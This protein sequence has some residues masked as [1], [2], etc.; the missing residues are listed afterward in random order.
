MNSTVQSYTS[1][2]QADDE[3]SL[4]DLLLVVAENFWLL[5]IGSALAAVLGFVIS[6]LLQ[7][8]YVSTA[9]VSGEHSVLVGGKVVPL[10]KPT[11][12]V[13]LATS[14]AT[15]SGAASALEQ[16]GY[17]AEA[18]AL[19]AQSSGGA[20][21][22]KASIARNSAAINL[23]ATAGSAQAAQEILIAVVDSLLAQSRPQAEAL[24]SLQ[25]AFQRDAATLERSRAIEASLAQRMSAT[26]SSGLEAAG[27]YANVLAAISALSASVAEQQARLQGL[28]ADSVLVA[29]SLP[30]QPVK[31]KRTLITVLSGLA[32]GFVLLLWVFVRQ[33]WRNAQADRVTLE[34]IQRIRQAFL[35][36]RGKA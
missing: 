27:A 30:Q 7:P 2:P 15:L 29:P 18:N 36:R 31:P 8:T 35:G 10:F 11:E 9:V 33:S 24:S 6:G 28:P 12:V 20:G 17:A 32:A 5:V 34:K 1:E 22:F 3:I 14:A 16:K 13:Q 23:E 21:L 19:L 25:A 26:A 4:L